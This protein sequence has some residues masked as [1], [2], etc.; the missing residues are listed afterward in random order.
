MSPNRDCGTKGVKGIVDASVH[1]PGNSSIS[2][3]FHNHIRFETNKKIHECAIHGID[4]PRVRFLQQPMCLLWPVNTFSGHHAIP[5][6]HECL[7][8]LTN[9]PLC[10]PL[11]TSSCVDVGLTFAVNTNDAFVGIDTMRLEKKRSTTV[12]PPAYDAG[13]RVR[14][15]VGLSRLCSGRLGWVGSGWVGLPFDAVAMVVI[16]SLEV[17][18]A[19]LI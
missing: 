4:M 19:G 13:K 9:N 17:G 3:I 7:K 18:W 16:G 11:L 6:G 10:F 14:A 12:Y 1:A 8:R 5:N 15:M 2:I